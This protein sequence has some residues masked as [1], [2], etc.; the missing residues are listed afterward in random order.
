MSDA[1]DNL[2]SN[3]GGIAEFQG[4]YGAFHVSEALLQK[5]WLRQQFAVSRARTTGGDAIVVRSPGRWNRLSGP[6]F[7]DARLEIGGRTVTGAIEVHFHADAWAQHHHDRDRAYDDV[8]LHVVLFPPDQES[9]LAVTSA[10]RVIPTL[11]LIDL[12]W[13]DLEAYAEDEAV[14]ALAGRDPLPLLEGLL[15][16]E[17]DARNAAIAASMERRWREKLRFASLRIERLGWAEACH[18]TALEILGYRQNR[19]PMLRSA[20]QFG[21]EA[22]REGRVTNEEAFAAAFDMWTTR[23]VRPANHPRHRLEQYADWVARMPDWPER[24]ATLSLPELPKNAGVPAG[25]LRKSSGAKELREKLVQQVFG[26]VVGGTRVDTL[27][28]DLVLPFLGTTSANDASRTL[29][30]IWY[31][32]D[33]PD[34]L[35]SV[36]RQLAEPRAGGLTNGLLQALFG[37][38]LQALQREAAPEG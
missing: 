35:R 15:A 11:V 14:A 3:S 31:P 32:G 23:G 7:H 28:I 36:A 12:L 13:Q 17:P 19:V 26:D 24:L 9:R 18:H 2:L 29:W 25:R 21:W 38:V 5:I 10:G 33:M 20:A 22:W 30:R 34:T 1:I 16:M 27:I 4:L 37:L 8:V 6:D